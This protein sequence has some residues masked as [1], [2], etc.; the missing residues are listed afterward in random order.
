MNTDPGIKKF[1][2]HMCSTPENWY[3]T[4]LPVSE[5]KFDEA[6][7][8]VSENFSPPDWTIVKNDFVFKH[9]QDAARFIFTFC[10]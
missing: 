5:T 10:I 4:T 9:E 8:W 1:F 6:W 7:D 3:N 2:A